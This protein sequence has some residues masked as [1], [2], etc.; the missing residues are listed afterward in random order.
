MDQRS[1]DS[2]HDRAVTSMGFLLASYISE[3]E[4][5]ESTTLKCQEIQRKTYRHM[6]IMH[7]LCI[8]YVYFH[9]YKKYF[10]NMMLFAIV[11]FNQAFRRHF[12]AL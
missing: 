4:L 5:K 7:I 1:Q 3:L 8:I 2:I 6:L 9:S 11:S 10:I 12:I